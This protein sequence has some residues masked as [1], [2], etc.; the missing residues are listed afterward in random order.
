MPSSKNKPIVDYI[1][2]FLDYS[3]KERNFLPKSIENYS[4]F[5]N[6][7]TT[8]LKYSN[9]IQLLPHQLFLE[10]IQDYKSY[11]SKQSISKST[12]NY[13]LIAL[14]ALFAYFD[15]KHITTLLPN[16]IKLLKEDSK[17]KS[18]NILNSEQ[19]KKLLSAPNVSILSGLRDRAILEIILST[20]LKINQLIA[21][22][23]DNIEFRGKSLEIRILNKQGDYFQ[24]TSLS[25][26][27]T[28][29]LKKYL[30]TRKDKE[31]ALFIN[32]RG[33]K[34][35]LR[36]LT[37]RSIQKST[38]RYLVDNNLT[39]SF[40]PETLRNVYIFYLLNQGI[41]I[42]SPLLHKVSTIQYYIKSSITSNDNLCNTRNG[43]SL[44]WHTV[45]N[46]LNKEIL[47][48][49][50]KISII[51]A[52]KYRNDRLSQSCDNCFF[53]KL[54][55]LIVSGKIK[56]IEFQAKNGIN[57][58]HGVISQKESLGI[59]KHG[60]D[61]HRKMMDIILNHFKKQNYKIILEPTLNYGRADLG[62]FPNQKEAIYI[63]VGTVSL[64]KLWYNLSTM[65][66]ITFL[67]IPNE[68]YIIEFMIS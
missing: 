56:A 39:S 49:K 18:E 14:R 4:R 43:K 53:R 52:T 54:A 45:E 47:W 9:Q 42:T 28:H 1:P 30:N 31:K 57:L 62:F 15:E 55:I 35:A 32:Y 17:A 61:W 26:N 63:E 41:K 20:G 59:R 16:K 48:L 24:I 11:L 60:K 46:I 36:R 7:F 23:R 37:D 2:D 21:L 29:W 38:K 50:E 68:E 40:T 65:K 58:W 10:H 12:Q 6:R 34:D 8:Y 22:N 5:L 44:P 66:N 19:L 13:Y 3:K 51:P 33:K 25:K 67:L 64:F 27:A